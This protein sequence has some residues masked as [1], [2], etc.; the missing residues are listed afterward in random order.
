MAQG[1]SPVRRPFAALT[2]CAAESR[3]SLISEDMPLDLD[4]PPADAAARAA[5]RASDTD[6]FVPEIGV[7]ANESRH[8]GEAARVLKHMDR[9][10]ARRE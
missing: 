3:G 8:E 6:V 5:R 1:F 2:R 7:L 10:A 4:Q 9:D